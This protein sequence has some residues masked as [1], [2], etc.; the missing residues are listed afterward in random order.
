LRAT[1]LPRQLSG[2][3][4]SGVLSRV[5]GSR[6]GRVR[7]ARRGPGATGLQAQTL[8]VPVKLMHRDLELALAAVVGVQH[9][10]LPWGRDSAGDEL[11]CGFDGALCPK[12]FGSLI[13]LWL[14]SRAP[15][16]SG[17]I[18]TWHDGVPANRVLTTASLRSISHQAY[19]RDEVLRHWHAPYSGVARAVATAARGAHIAGGRG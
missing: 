6:D 4:T 8:V 13:F 5:A 2:A 19:V 12:S 15:A 18:T 14:S 9:E 10:R 7:G 16:R 1:E 3:R 17:S 11:L